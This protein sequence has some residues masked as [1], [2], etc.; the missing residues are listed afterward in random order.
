[1]KRLGLE[2]AR[3]PTRKQVLDVK[4]EPKGDT[5]L[6]GP[7]FGKDDPKNEPHVGGNTWA[8]GVSL[9]FSLESDKVLI[10][11]YLGRRTRYC[12]H[13]WQRRVHALI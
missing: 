4:F 13:G 5:K 11:L 9:F 1:M 8:G 7:K 2:A 3:D 10:E 12:W 6:G